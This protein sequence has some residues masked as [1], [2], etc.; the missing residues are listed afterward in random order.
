MA[1]NQGPVY[2]SEKLP[3]WKA[4]TMQ[5]M[6]AEEWESLCDGCARCCLYKIEDEDNQVYYTNVVCRLLDIDAC[7]CTTYPTRHQEMPSCILLGPNNVSELSWLPFTCAYRLVA[8]G[9]DL[10]WWHPLISGDA[11][12]VRL[13]GISVQ[14]YAIPEVEVDMQELEEYIIDDLSKSAGK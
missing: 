4:K 14:A 8:E 5:E 3:F 6:T 7:Q 12:T 10:Y 13:A 1:N 9:K 2:S 11:Q